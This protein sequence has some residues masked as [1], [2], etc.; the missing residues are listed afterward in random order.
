MIEDV[1]FE[2][3]MR[4]ISFS[5]GTTILSMDEYVKLFGDTDT[6]VLDRPSTGR[7]SK[8]DTWWTVKVDPFRCGCG[9][10]TSYA[11]TQT[12]PHRIIVWPSEDD[13]NLSKWL[14]TVQGDGT[15]FEVVEYEQSMGDAVS[16]YE[17]HPR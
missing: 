16:F 3:V 4:E 14:A 17:I 6:A 15:D 8:F 7:N 10:E 12:K 5:T 13:P 11:V 9:F 2:F 1:L